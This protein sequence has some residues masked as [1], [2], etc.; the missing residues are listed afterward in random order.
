MH[1]IQHEAILDPVQVDHWSPA[2]SAA[3]RLVNNFIIMVMVSAPALAL[4]SLG[5]STE[6]E[7]YFVTAAS[8]FESWV[9]PKHLKLERTYFI[10]HGR[11]SDCE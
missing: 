7:A 2:S 5:A 8:A 3:M 11:L 1:W 9:G 4:R 10:A 6:S